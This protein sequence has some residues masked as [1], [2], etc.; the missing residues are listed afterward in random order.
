MV[1]DTGS[2]HADLTDDYA[3]IPKEMGKVAAYFG[4]KVLSGITYDQFLQ[5]LAPLRE[6]LK[7]DRALLRA[8]HFILENQRVE[9]MVNA[10]REGQIETYLSLV[11]QSGAS[12]FNYLQNLYSTNYV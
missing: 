6:T 11:R 2:T 5:H 1:V 8:H 4:Q 10:L 9:G 7:N 3:S 12:S